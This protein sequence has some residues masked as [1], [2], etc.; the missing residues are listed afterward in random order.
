MRAHVW[1]GH[2]AWLTVALITA[3]C[4]GGTT[5]PTPIPPIALDLICPDDIRTESLNGQSVLVNFDTPQPSGGAAPVAVSCTPQSGAMFS[6]GATP[7]TCAVSDSRGQTNSCGFTV[8]VMPPPRLALTRFLAFGDSL[9]EG[10]LGLAPLVLGV[11]FGDAY[12]SKLQSLLQARYTTQSIVVVHD[13]VGGER[14]VGI[15]E[16]SPGGVVRLPQ[17][18]NASQPE[19]LLLMEG[20]NDLGGGREA[21]QIAIDGLQD[22]I[23]KAKERGVRVFLATVP[24]QRAGG[25][26]NRDAVAAL[27]PE[28][29]ENVRA[30]AVREGVTLV[31]VYDVMKD[32]IDLIGPDDLHLTAQGYEVVAQAFF[33]AIKGSL[34]IQSAAALR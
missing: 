12:S 30:L 31:D 33:A 5:R 26:R 4:G 18:L 8:T 21:G 13:G 17:S 11:V 20:S 6:I 25:L 34:E 19:V 9:T 29:N 22:M 15:T 3:G 32:R 23:E 14:V 2:A 1:V 28:F 27:I 24:P 7:V 10:K 16:H